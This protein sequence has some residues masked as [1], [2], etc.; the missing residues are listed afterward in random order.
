MNTPEQL[1]AEL[2]KYRE[3]FSGFLEDYAP[4]L[5]STRYTQS[6]IEFLW[7]RETE[8]DRRDFGNVLDG[9][10]AWDKVDVPHFG[11]PLGKKVTYYRTTFSV[12]PRQLDNKALFLRFKAVDYIAHVFINKSYAGSHEGFFAPFEFDITDYVSAGEN[13]LTVKVE[14]DFISLG[15]VD[16]EIPADWR[17]T[18]YN[19]DKIYAATGVGYDDPER[20]WHHCPPGM[21]IYQD[22]FLESRSRIHLSDV[23]VRP[24]PAENKAEVR[25]EICNCDT[26][27]VEVSINL[28]LYGQNFRQVIFE[29]IIH[30]P[31]TVRE[32]GYGDDLEEAK[33]LAA[34]KLNEKMALKIEGGINY[35]RFP[36]DVPGKRL[37]E[38]E[39]PWLYQLQVRLHNKNGQIIEAQKQ[40]FGMRSFVIEDTCPDLKGGF[41]FNGRKIRLRGANTMG[42]LQ[43]CVFKKDFYQLIDDIL[44]AKICNMNF[45]RLTQ[46]PVNKEIYEYCDRLGMMT[47]TDL[48]L[49]GVLRRNKFLEAVRQAEEM[50]RLI[51]PHACNILISYINEPFSNS[52]NA[53]H[54]HLDRDSLH[55][56]FKAADIAVHMQNSDRQIKYVDGDYD[57]PA[58]GIPD[59]HCYTC[60]YNGMGVALGKLHK[61]FWQPIRGGY[62]FGCGEFGAEALDP[63]QIMRKYYPGEWLP[64]TAEEEKSW[65]PDYIVKAQT[66]SFHYM[67]YDTP[68]SLEEWVMASHKHQALSTKMMTEAFRRER[69]MN[70][71]AIHLFIDAFPSGWMKAVMDVE[72]NPKPSYFAYREALTPLMVNLRSDRNKYISGEEMKTEAWVCNDLS[73]PEQKLYLHYMIELN[74]KVIFA[75]KTEA[76]IPENSSRFQGYICYKAPV[77]KERTP[78]KIRLA[79][80]DE[81]S[82][83]YFDTEL[84]PEIFPE[85]EPCCGCD[86]PV[87]GQEDGPARSFAEDLDINSKTKKINDKTKVILI[88]DYEKYEQNRKNIDEAVKNGARA[89]FFEL[90]P[91][92]Y[93]IAGSPVE[94][95]PCSMNPVQF[96]SRKTGHPLVS[97]F[98]QDDFKFWYDEQA[99]YITPILYNTFLADD[100]IPVLTSGNLNPD[101]VWDKALAA[102]EKKYGS[103]SFIIN[104][105]KLAGRLKTNPAAG[106]FAGRLIKNDLEN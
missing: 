56:F 70:T 88:D 79:L 67:F 80:I 53:P 52:N 102:A 93:D 16:D 69:R 31:D 42:H 41:V 63:V 72:R 48:P 94:V 30:K 65:N 100:F 50:E 92:K 62:Y 29:N 39:S 76:E 77:V 40:Q 103:G 9:D 96:V 32:I 74:G 11:G 7:R 59:R 44:L 91:G 36:I 98:L 45:L 58:P 43:Q 84:E 19:G 101:N 21:G 60:W 106:I 12:A 18:V 55:L 51:R 82:N 8:K 81:K 90:P 6:L 27:H 87:L 23:F 47:Q 46:R 14:N 10:G 97:G 35:F 99:G 3:R 33:M 5:E 71:F 75:S 49:F 13:V 83:I 68:S 86:I 89:V 78:V 4:E 57:P 34:G 2:I 1:K 104:Q 17:E 61:G 64:Q 15:S 37:W 54:R 38:P 20:G 85:P 95:K 25:L 22:V 24:I 73:V 66:G 28:S 26:E 105:V